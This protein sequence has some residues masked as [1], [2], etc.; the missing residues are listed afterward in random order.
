MPARCA[1]GYFV[2]A[3]WAQQEHVTKYGIHDRVITDVPSD[4]I[5]MVQEL[6]ADVSDYWSTLVMRRPPY[7][8]DLFRQTRPF[9]KLTM[10]T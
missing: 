6:L 3:L 10:C 4:K 1:L 8:D 9:H 7:R 5:T 2:R